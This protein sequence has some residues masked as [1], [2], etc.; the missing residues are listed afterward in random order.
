MKVETR[1]EMIEMEIKKYIANDGTEFKSKIDCLRYEERQ[2]RKEEIEAAEK[3]RI[4]DLDEQIPLYCGEMSE[5]NTF[6]WYRVE[7]DAEFDVLNNACRNELV[8]ARPSVY[9]EIICVETVGYEAYED[10]VYSYNMEDIKAATKEFFEKFGYR[11]MIELPL[12]ERLKDVDKI[13]DDQ[14]FC[15]TEYNI[16]HDYCAE[17]DYI[18][19]KDDLAVIESRGLMES[20]ECW[21]EQATE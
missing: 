3:L 7:N 15:E 5:N 12:A 20:F 11:V 1:K 9:P 13:K 16:I 17:H 14:E 4:E 19:C 21:K 2:K 6:R 8:C 10:D 18:L